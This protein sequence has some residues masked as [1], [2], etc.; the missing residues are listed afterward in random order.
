MARPSRFS[1]EVR[2]R[3]VRMVIQWRE[4]AQLNLN[5][6]WLLYCGKQSAGIRR[7]DVVRPCRGREE[8]HRSDQHCGAHRHGSARGSNTVPRAVGP[9]GFRLGQLE[10]RMSS[11]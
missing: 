8:I 5:W 9:E 11:E 1:P 10:G 7:E 2:E 4:I 3:A 6:I